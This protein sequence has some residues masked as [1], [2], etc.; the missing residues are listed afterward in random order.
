[1]NY[2]VY[3]L[4]HVETG[5]FYYGSRGCKCLPHEDNYMGSMYVWNPDKS[6]LIK[7]VVKNRK[8]N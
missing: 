4:Y 5:E 6:K 1:M 7:N 3:K 8:K 2:Y